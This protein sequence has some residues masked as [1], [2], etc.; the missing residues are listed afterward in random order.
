MVSVSHEAVTEVLML[1]G[2]HTEGNT[3]AVFGYRW[4][5]TKD[6]GE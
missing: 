5:D 1:W 3:A 2:S 6:A 4:K